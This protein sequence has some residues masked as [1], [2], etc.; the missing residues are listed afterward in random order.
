MGRLSEFFGKK[1]YLDTNV[2]I[3]ALEG[4]PDYSGVL[5]ALFQA[6]DQELLRAFTSELTIAEVL[7]KPFIDRN[8]EREHAYLELFD[9]SGP[10]HVE[11]VTRSILIEAARLRALHPLRLPDEIHLATAFFSECSFFITND[12]RINPVSGLDVIRLSEL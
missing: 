9:G 3:Y 8:R 2:L 1:I 4:F 6:V 7:V 5:T 10:L 12:F 11:P